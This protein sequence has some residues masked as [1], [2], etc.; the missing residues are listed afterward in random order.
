MTVRRLVAADV[1]GLGW[2]DDGTREGLA[3][4]VAAGPDRALVLAG[5]D[6]ADAPVGVLAVDLPPWRERAVP[7]MWLVEVRSGDRG[8]GVGSELLAEAHR[9]LTGGGHAAVEL[10]VEDRNSRAAALYRR[11]GYAAVGT[12]ADAGAAGPEPWTWMRL[13]LAA[14]QIRRNR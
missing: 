11:L 12:G 3:V 2:L 7:W 4:A 8:R 1:A 9:L 5:L 6:A 10:S 13:E 14:D